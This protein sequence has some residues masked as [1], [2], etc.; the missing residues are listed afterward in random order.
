MGEKPTVDSRQPLANSKKT[1]GSG[2]ERT[3]RPTGELSVFSCKF[4]VS[5]K[6]N[7]RAQSGVTVPQ[8]KP[9]TQ[10]Q[11]RHLGHPQ[12]KRRKETTKRG[13]DASNRDV[14]KNVSETTRP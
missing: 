5:E 14:G 1:M 3:P 2:S 8:E 11:N 7:P 4:S 12:T 13:W 6:R 9:K 10:V